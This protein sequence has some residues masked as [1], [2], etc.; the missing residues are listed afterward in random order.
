MG[1]FVLG[2]ALLVLP[3]AGGLGRA[4]TVGDIQVCYYSSTCL[5]NSSA[6]NLDGPVF[7]I[8][9]TSGSAFT[10]VTFSINDGGS[11]VDTFT[12]GTLGAGMNFFLIPGVTNDGGSGHNF[13]KVTGGIVDTS[14]SGPSSNSVSFLL[15]GS[16]GANTITTNVFTPATSEFASNDNAIMLMNFLGGPGD[17]DAPC[18][19]C[20][21]PHIVAS[22]TTVTS[23]AVPEPATLGLLGVGLA[24]IVLRRRFRKQENLQ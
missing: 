21:G 6:T 5:G 9:N 8:Q 10:N 17:N 22:I 18:G 4:A 15:F 16:Q 19:N 20:Y 3:F 14:D 2:A 11:N 7:V 24:G 1:R 23:S 12:L 13:F